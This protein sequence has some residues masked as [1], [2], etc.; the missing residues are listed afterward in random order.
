MGK[1]SQSL[2]GP[3][4]N[5]SDFCYTN[6]N[7]TCTHSHVKLSHMRPYYCKLTYIVADVKHIRGGVIH[8]CLHTTMYAINTSCCCCIWNTSIDT[9]A[10]TYILH[11][12]TLQHTLLQFLNKI[13]LLRPLLDVWCNEEYM[14]QFFTFIIF[15]FYYLC[16]ALWSARDVVKVLNK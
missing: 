10:H 11:T 9:F 5:I 14:L 15:W 3:L 16:K 12:Y 2:R 7:Q 6:T 13:F 1:N 8:T 4:G